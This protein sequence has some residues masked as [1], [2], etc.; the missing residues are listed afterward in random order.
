MGKWVNSKIMFIL[1]LKKKL[2]VY[3]TYTFKL[4]L[5]NNIT[6]SIWLYM[7]GLNYNFI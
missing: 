1:V 5:Y 2:H 3:V 4:Q 7:A 6:I